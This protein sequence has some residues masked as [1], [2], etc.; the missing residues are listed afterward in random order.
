MSPLQ[1]EILLQHFYS[2]RGYSGQ[3]KG[4]IAYREAMIDFEARGLL[5]R[6]HGD[7]Y[8]ITD[9]GTECVGRL[10]AVPM[11]TQSSTPRTQGSG[12]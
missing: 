5:K 11:V 8:E 4:S 6:H 9:L 7:V 1:I 3:A 10:C 12:A 2:P